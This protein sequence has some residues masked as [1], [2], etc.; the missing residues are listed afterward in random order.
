MIGGVLTS[1]LPRIISLLT[2]IW[3]GLAWEGQAL[4]Q[5]DEGAPLIIFQIRGVVTVNNRVA[6]VQTKLG[7][8]SIL[9]LRP[10]ASVIAISPRE[11]IRLEGPNVGRIDDLLAQAE[12]HAKGA[13]SA[14]AL[15]LIYRLLSNVVNIVATRDSNNLTFE[16][17]WLLRLETNGP[18]C[19]RDGMLPVFASR[20]GERKQDIGLLNVKLNTK[21]FA[22]TGSKGR[23]DWPRGVAIYDG[24]VYEVRTSDV[25]HA[26]SWTFRIVPVTVKDLP[27]VTSWFIDAGC[28]DQVMAIAAHIAEARVVRPAKSEKR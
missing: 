16:D 28:L 6:E 20:D 22:R 10:N 14:G 15:E 4:G 25:P 12:T 18:K 2:V 19:I 9:S 27:E 5:V 11:K 8:Q 23:L 3:G 24:D 13:E 1:C 21:S 17:P 7:S 26:L